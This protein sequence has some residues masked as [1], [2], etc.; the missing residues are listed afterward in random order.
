M[1]KAGEKDM[2][3]L[4]TRAR[5]AGAEA[6]LTYA[7]GGDLTTIA[8]GMEKLGWKVPII[9][10]WTLASLNFIDG[11][12]A[13][14]EGATMPQTFV[15]APSTPKRAAFIEA[16]QKRF[17]TG[18]MPSPPAAAQCYDAIYLLAAAM[19][20][21]KST[22]GPKIRE[23]LEN[24]G[25]RMEGVVTTY[26]HPFSEGDHE[27]ITANIPVLGVVR[28]GRVVPAHPEDFADK[29]ARIKAKS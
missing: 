21:A 28:N 8:N 26:D 12:G 18:R 23:A 27:A 6:V 4:L 24:L 10:S 17:G 20:Q 29:T 1:F 14:A 9:G 7:A 11:A 2:L 22:E 5:D 15:Q 25:K 13:N 3:P 19:E 16:Y